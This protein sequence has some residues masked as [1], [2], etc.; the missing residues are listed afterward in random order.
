MVST[1]EGGW[2]CFD[3]KGDRSDHNN[4]TYYSMTLICIV[5]VRIILLQPSCLS[6]INVEGLYL[7]EVDI[8]NIYLCMHPHEDTSK[9]GAYNQN[10]IF[11]KMD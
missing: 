8:I 6:L 7:S 11:E 10:Y 2:C 1:V 9:K 5:D 3:K 4:C